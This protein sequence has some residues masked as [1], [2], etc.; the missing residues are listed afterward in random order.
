MKLYGE[1]NRV[2]MIGIGGSGMSGIAEIL[3]NIGYKVRG[4][5]INTESDTVQYLRKLGI[6]ILKGHRKKNIRDEQVVVYSSAI[7]EDN[8]ELVEAKRRGVL[9]LRRAEM[10]SEL[11]RLKFGIAVS[12]SHGKTTTTSI[13]GQILEVSK[14]QPTVVVGGIVKNFG[15]SAK[16][17]KGNLMVV[18]ADESDGTF[19]NFSP[20]VSII[21]NIDKE[22]LDH[23]GSF[24]KL[25]EAFVKFAN[26]VPFY[27]ISILSADDKIS[28]GIVK[29]I[30]RIV[31][32]FGFLKDSNVRG[33]ILDK[34][35]SSFKV[36]YNGEEQGI[37]NMKI[38][39][40][41]NV[42]NALAAIT[43]ACYL[44]IPFSTIKKALE[45][46]EG[47]GRRFD[48]KYEDNTITVV[49]DYGHHPTEIKATL[50]VAKNR[51]KERLIVVFQPHRFTRTR[52]LLKVFPKAF[53]NADLIILTEIY[54]AGEKPIKGINSGVLYNEFKAQGFKNIIYIKKM[55][56]IIDK[57]I[58]IKDKG[59]L[60]IF[61]GAGNIRNIIPEFIRRVK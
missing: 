61:Q 42:K 18:E 25:K 20:V 23:Y 40:K 56:A 48:I 7:S 55:N 29:N 32:T 9:V 3:H 16:V 13:L 49:E 10:L 36:F 19:L 27:G 21:T 4:S 6:E 30:K 12:G 44:K 34:R 43:A 59:D 41:H 22:H 8:S 57:L 2:F 17:G 45:E 47:V 31:K 28:K 37:V 26:S 33:E 60:V 15:T 11:M 53:K 5:D 52:D 1:I 54:P 51:K 35:A 50:E 58:E 38:E 46:F 24:S 39:G 14:F